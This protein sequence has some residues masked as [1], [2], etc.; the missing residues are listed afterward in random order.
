MGIQ[1]RCSSDY[2]LLHHVFGKVNGEKGAWGHAM[3][4]MGDIGAIAQ[5]ICKEAEYLGVTI[6]IKAEVKKV[7]IDGGRATGVRLSSRE[8]ITAIIVVTNVDSKLLYSQMIREQHQ[9]TE[10]RRRVRGFRVGSGT[11]HMNVT[12]YELPGFTCK[13]GTHLQPHHQPRIVIDPTMNYLE[14]A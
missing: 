10:F 9:E 11:F 3:G 6:R 7:L 13:H 4:D 8:T 14:Q 1:H 2:E 5:A 12:L